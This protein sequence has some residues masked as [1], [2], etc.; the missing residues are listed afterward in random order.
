MPTLLLACPVVLDGVLRD[1]Q[2]AGGWTRRAVLQATA[3]A[4]VSRPPLGL[5]GYTD[6]RLLSAPGSTSVELAAPLLRAV[7]DIAT[8]RCYGRVTWLFWWGVSHIHTNELVHFLR[9]DAATL[10]AFDAAAYEHWTGGHPCLIPPSA[11]AP[12]MPR[13]RKK[14]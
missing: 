13:R 5:I 2:R 9:S 12:R 3:R 7:R 1:V 4:V 14:K 8:H 11:R 6:P 10:A